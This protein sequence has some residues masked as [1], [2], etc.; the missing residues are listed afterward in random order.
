MSQR[1]KMMLEL[2][3]SE[4]SLLRRFKAINQA[5]ERIRH[6]IKN[7]LIGMK[8]DSLFYYQFFTKLS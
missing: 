3:L 2:M 8:T 7:K 6:P 4:A 5:I 1:R